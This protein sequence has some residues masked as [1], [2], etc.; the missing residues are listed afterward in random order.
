[1]SSGV[2][3][4]QVVVGLF[5]CRHLRLYETLGRVSSD[6]GRN[7]KVFLRLAL[8]ESLCYDKTIM[9]T[10]HNL[11][12]PLMAL[13]GVT[14]GRRLTWWRT[15]A[16]PDSTITQAELGEV[17][18][19]SE[20]SLSGWEKGHR[21]PLAKTADRIEEIAGIPAVDWPRPEKTSQVS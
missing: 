9:D 8:A 3:P 12:A 14:P 6:L 4:A 5:P 21:S 15:L 2:S 1:M 20:F 17:L 19:V 10:P 13:Q 18:D 16:R 11:I 7:L